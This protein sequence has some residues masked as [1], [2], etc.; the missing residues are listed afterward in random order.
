M[1][2]YNQLKGLL[3]SDGHKAGDLLVSPDSK[4]TDCVSGL[5]IHR[6]L[7]CQLRQHLQVMTLLLIAVATLSYVADAALTLLLMLS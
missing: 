5:S 7:S 1:E 2:S 6:L 4:G 3:A